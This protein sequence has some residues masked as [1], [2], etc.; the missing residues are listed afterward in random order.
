[1]RLSLFPSLYS[2]IMTT[3][4]KAAKLN[5]DLVLPIISGLCSIMI[6]RDPSN[7]ESEKQN[8]LVDRFVLEAR[9]RNDP[10]H[11]CRALSMKAWYCARLGIFK[12]ALL[13][14]R[15]LKAVYD[16]ELHSDGIREEYG[17]DYAV[18]AMA[19]AVQ[20]YCLEE[21][22]DDALQQIDY[23][24]GSLVPHLDLSDVDSVME[25]IFPVLMVMKT[26][27]RCDEAQ[28]LLFENAINPYHDLN[29]S[30]AFAVKLF[31]PLAYLLYI[32][33]M[34][35]EDDYDE[36]ML[37]DMENWVLNP[38]N[39]MFYNDW[40]RK[41]TMLIGEICWR[42]VKHKSSVGEPCVLLQELG[43]RSLMRIVHGP[44]DDKS[45]TYMRNSGRVMLLALDAFEDDDDD[46]NNDDD[47]GVNHGMMYGGM[48]KNG[49]NTRG[50]DGEISNHNH[51]YQY[52][53]DDNDD[54]NDDMGFG[55]G[56]MQNRNPHSD[57]SYNGH[58][59]PHHSYE[60]QDDRT[61][62]GQQLAYHHQHQQQRQH[63]PH[64]PYQYYNNGNGNSNGS[65]HPNTNGTGPHGKTAIHESPLQSSWEEE[66][67]MGERSLSRHGNGSS[68]RITSNE[69]YTDEEGSSERGDRPRGDGI[70][71]TGTR[72][73][74]RSPPS[75]V[76]T[77]CR[78]TIL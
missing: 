54:N 67:K 64:H 30:S 40:E 77:C 33:N 6:Q 75:Q 49:G 63:H 60:S 73:L 38:D 50:I 8:E 72:R 46:D 3:S 9:D 2:Q 21:A 16:V 35:E 68:N 55:T 41:G 70:D 48:P 51:H 56:K 65:V 32:I 7:E 37:R 39:L 24:V 53:G 5:E 43:R 11:I 17:K 45:D 69:H 76:M 44:D 4:P 1:M 12:D 13:A 18:Q 22:F 20:W 19:D 78:C 58:Q 34:E 59:D 28:Q 66:K 47:D 52:R 25:I 15:E 14:Q 26:M 23:V 36:P 62:Y 42:L 27:G 57:M 71:R 74:F 61:A 29:I 31:N 10:I